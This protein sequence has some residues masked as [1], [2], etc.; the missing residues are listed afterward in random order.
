MLPARRRSGAALPAHARSRRAAKKY[1][2]GVSREVRAAATVAPAAAIA[3][4]DTLR[5]VQTYVG[6]APER[7]LARH[8]IQDGRAAL[9]SSSTA[10]L[11]ITDRGHRCRSKRVAVAW[12]A[13][14]DALVRRTGQPADDAWVPSAPRVRGVRRHALL[15]RQERVTLTG[16]RVRRRP[17]RLEQ[18]RRRRDAQRR[19][20]RRPTVR[21]RQS[22]TRCRRP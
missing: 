14:Y 7:A 4:D 3:D 9:R 8:R 5:F 19:H 22:K 2:A 13:W 18:L 15:R 11:K 21:R 20:H 16:D 17:A 10:A 12:L 1:R 6:R